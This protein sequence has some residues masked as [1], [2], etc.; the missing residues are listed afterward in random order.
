MFPEIHNICFQFWG[1]IQIQ[2]LPEIELH[3]TLYQ[4]FKA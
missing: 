1:S 3:H 2:A 4:Q